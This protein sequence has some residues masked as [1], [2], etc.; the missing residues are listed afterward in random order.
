[1]DHFNAFIENLMRKSSTLH[2]HP[3]TLNLCCRADEYSKLMGLNAKLRLLRHPVPDGPDLIVIRPQNS[4]GWRRTVE[5]R[6][7]AAAH[8]AVSI[9]IG[10][11]RI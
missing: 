7:G 11:L 5:D 4:K 6:D 10:Q 3:G 9:Q 2:N 1:M 8:L